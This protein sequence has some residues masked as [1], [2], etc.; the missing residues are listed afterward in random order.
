MIVPSEITHAA[1][2]KEI[3]EKYS[4]WDHLEELAKT[5][6]AC[7]ILIISSWLVCFAFS[8][9][10][11]PVLYI[12]LSQFANAPALVLLSPLD[13]MTTTA[14]LSFWVSLSVTSPIWG[15]WLL[16]FCLP[17]LQ[18]KERTRL[19]PFLG[20][21]LLTCI[22]SGYFAWAVTLPL[23]NRFLVMWSLPLGT[24][25]WSISAYLDYTL[26]LL[27]GHMVAGQICLIVLF[28]VHYGFV[29]PKRLRLH[30][31]MVIIAILIISALLTPPDI[32]TQLMMAGPLYGLYEAAI[33]YAQWKVSQRKMI[34]FSAS[35]SV[36]S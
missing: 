2:N 18:Q 22:L 29:T 34:L 10:L 12:P 27:F 5:L 9:Y 36:A 24:P 13:A 11:L 17:A 35:N 33:L 6:R 23:A 32:M 30:R 16:R 20:F 25:M 4:F 31:K 15:W 14:Q 3:T 7:L 1:L 19:F 26:M 28:A 8:S 21:S